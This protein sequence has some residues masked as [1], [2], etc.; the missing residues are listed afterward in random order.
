MADYNLYARPNDKALMKLFLGCPDYVRRVVITDHQIDIIN[1]LS[2]FS[3]APCTARQL[4]N[5]YATSIQSASAQLTKLW[6]RGYLERKEARDPTGGIYYLY[7]A[8][9]A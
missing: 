1:W 6:H 8:S 5:R 3:P 4:A 9:I 2:S 7:R